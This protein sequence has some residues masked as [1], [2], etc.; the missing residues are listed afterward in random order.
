MN[1]KKLIELLAT[2]IQKQ[3]TSHYFY[4]SLVHSEQVLEFLEDLDVIKDYEEPEE[5]DCWD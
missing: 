1:R 3:N 2:Q 4:N 5:N